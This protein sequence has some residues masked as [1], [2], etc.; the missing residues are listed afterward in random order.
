MVACLVLVL[1]LVGREVLCGVVLCHVVLRCVALCCVACL[2]LRSRG[3]CVRQWC[4]RRSVCVRVCAVAAAS[5]R[6][7]RFNDG[8]SR[9]CTSTA[10][11]NVLG[12]GVRGRGRARCDVMGER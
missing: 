3:A 10:E 4:R 5:A 6:A 1:V 9:L 11:L 12:T 8:R 7:L 2:R